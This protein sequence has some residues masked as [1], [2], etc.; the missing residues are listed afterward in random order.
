MKNYFNLPK[1]FID[2]N[3][4]NEAR[5]VYCKVIQDKSGFNY[6]G[7][8]CNL[9]QFTFVK[10]MCELKTAGLIEFEKFRKSYY[11]I[12]IVFSKY[13]Y[14]VEN[15]FFKSFDTIEDFF[16]NLL[17]KITKARNNWRQNIRFYTNRIKMQKEWILNKLGDL[18]ETEQAVTSRAQRLAEGRITP[19]E[20]EAERAV[21]RRLNM[22]HAIQVNPKQFSYKDIM[23][24]IMD[25][26][27]KIRQENPT[28]SVAQVLERLAQDN[29]QLWSLYVKNRDYRQGKYEAKTAKI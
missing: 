21:H 17:V 4:S 14:R 7:K 29:V 10:A 25:A 24:K 18:L 16:I 8:Q 23:V 6:S 9:E 20:A 19:E 1:I 28:M 13:Y 2:A 12:K 11:K 27:E 26:K 3:I 15:E 5:A 22:L